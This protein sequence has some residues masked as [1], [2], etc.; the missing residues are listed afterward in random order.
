MTRQVMTAQEV[1]EV[2]DISATS[3]YKLIRE[4]NDELRGRGYIT[5]RGRVSRAYFNEKMYGGT[6]AAGRNEVAD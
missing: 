1:A 6:K 2:L 5:V 4:L 3:A